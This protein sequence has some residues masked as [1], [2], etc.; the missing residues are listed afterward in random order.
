MAKTLNFTNFIL[1]ITEQRRKK[2]KNNDFLLSNLFYQAE[3]DL[4]LQTTQSFSVSK[5]ALNDLSPRSPTIMEG[6]KLFAT[7]NLSGH[8]STPIETGSNVSA[9]TSMFE[10]FAHCIFLIYRRT[11]FWKIW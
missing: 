5:A 7:T 9:T 1:T 6:D 4:S 2:N 11:Q 8:V 3:L 10:P